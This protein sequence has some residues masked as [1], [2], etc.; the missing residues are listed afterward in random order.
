MSNAQ[1]TKDR[2]YQLHSLDEVLAHASEHSWFV[3]DIA[4]TPQDLAVRA[5][6]ASGDCFE[7]LGSSLDQISRRLKDSDPNQA[8]LEYLIRTLLYLQRHYK[9]TKR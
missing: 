1:N 6:V 9:I 8:E 3:R 2:V 4:G 7:M 5:L